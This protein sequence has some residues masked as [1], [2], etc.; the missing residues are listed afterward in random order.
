MNGVT[1]IGEEFYGG[2][3]L[4][5]LSLEDLTIKDLPRLKEWSCIENGAAVFPCLQKLIVDKCPNLISPRVFQYLPH[6]ELRDCHP[7][8][9]ESMENLSSLS[10][11][12]VDALQGLV[13]L[14]GKFLENNKSLETGNTFMQMF[15][16]S[17]SRDIAFHRSE[18]TDH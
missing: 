14:S 18:V 1:H 11:L 7:K 6:L 15:H 9:L 3:T 16:F 10:N 17:S 4:K 5:F 13:H 12:V 2:K 8:I